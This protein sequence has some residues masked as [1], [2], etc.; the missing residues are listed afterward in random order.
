MLYNTVNMILLVL[1]ESLHKVSTKKI[2][3][4][5]VKPFF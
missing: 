3:K 1:Y 5:I 2:V 4:R